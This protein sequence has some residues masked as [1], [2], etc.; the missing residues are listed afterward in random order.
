LPKILSG[1]KKLTKENLESHQ[2]D[3]KN[4][5]ELMSGMKEKVHSSEFL[6]RNNFKLKGKLKN[7]LL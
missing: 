7:K 4:L 6:F 3:L 5:P 1:R 2:K